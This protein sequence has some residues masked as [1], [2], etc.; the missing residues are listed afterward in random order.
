MYKWNASLLVNKCHQKWDFAS[1][2]IHHYIL[3]PK[4]MKH[5]LLRKMDAP[6]FCIIE[7]RWMDAVPDNNYRPVFDYPS[8][9]HHNR[10]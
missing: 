9:S 7:S 4:L 2:S 1:D 10:I 3:L 5:R 8:I 6:I